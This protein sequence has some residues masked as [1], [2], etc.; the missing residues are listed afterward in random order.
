MP[1]MDT[2]I[3]ALNY[4]LDKQ[5]LLAY[6]TMALT[7]RLTSVSFFQLVAGDKWGYKVDSS[8]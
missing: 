5:L 3:A 8:G 4:V 1:T 7:L 2:P 6:K